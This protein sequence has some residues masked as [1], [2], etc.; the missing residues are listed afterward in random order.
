MISVKKIII[1]L[2]FT[3][4]V[5]ALSS[6]AAAPNW[7]SGD[8]GKY[9]SEQYL[10]GRGVGSTEAEAQNRARGDLATIFEVRIAVVNENTTTVA[11]SGKNEQVNRLSSQQVS[12]KTDKVISGI[13][14]AE[15]WRDPVTQ[16]VHALAVLPRAQASTSLREELGKIDDDLQQQLQAVQVASDPLL[17]VSALS[18]ALQASIKREGFQT[19]LKV[20]DPSGRGSPAPI[21]QAAIQRMMSEN[22]KSIRIAPEV[23]EDADQK[24]FAGILKGGLA[25]A[26][27]LASNSANADLVLEGKLSMTDLGRRDGW[28][29]TRGSV[30][31]SL[32]EKDSG[33]VRGSQTW[34]VKASAQDE[35]TARKRA[36]NEVDK[37]LKQELRSAL[38]G[39]AEH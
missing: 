2:F 1:A 24:E 13:N 14:I 33:R 28:F 11:Q 32:I 9:P 12:A 20:I 27:F 37:V 17:K 29:W 6:V 16:D 19:T 26:G 23:I 15:I 30:E 3:L 35:R 22:L 5:S 10:I 25:A 34:P 31:V 21:S 4:N 38:I 7:V 36:L 18:Q 39:F 8:P